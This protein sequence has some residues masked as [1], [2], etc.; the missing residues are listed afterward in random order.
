MFLG[1]SMLLRSLW[2]LYAPSD[3]HKGFLIMM[4]VWVQASIYSFLHLF[5]VPEGSHVG[6]LKK[7]LFLM[8]FE[9]WVRDV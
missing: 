3:L 8:G 2:G 5:L 1:K 4:R 7:L 9:W 6:V